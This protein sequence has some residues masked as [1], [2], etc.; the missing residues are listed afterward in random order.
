M[1]LSAQIKT[2]I[3]R[4]LKWYSYSLLYFLVASLPC[5]YAWYV[6]PEPYR[7]GI[8]AVFNKIALMPTLIL[9]GA[10][11]V[12][13]LAAI[14][15]TL[16]SPWLKERF[17]DLSFSQKSAG[18]SDKDAYQ[19][20]SSAN[21]PT[22]LWDKTVNISTSVYGILLIVFG[23]GIALWLSKPYVT[24]LFSSS[25]IEAL[26]RKAARFEFV[27]RD[28]MKRIMENRARHEVSQKWLEKRGESLAQVQEDWI[29]IPIALVD[30]PILEGLSEENLALG[31]CRVSESSVPGQGGNCIIEGHNLSDF[32]WWRPQG[33]F[34]MLEVLEEGVHIY[35]FHKG[36]KYVYQVK[37][38]HYKDANDLN[39]YDFTPGERLTLITC[40][41]SWELAAYTNKR[42]VIVAYPM[43]GYN[44]Q[45]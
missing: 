31:V 22:G 30:E 45:I 2:S 40:T 13:I 32:G 33:P 44:P 18:L 8:Q 3:K 10:I 21:K 27:Q 34:N 35:V 19:E 17:P 16:I 28:A 39:L 12:L 6:R 24:F 4:Y 36:K 38:K 37:E 11:T 7:A 20:S 1:S 25:K 41:S 29:I 23:L 15:R 9:I 42:T 5:A 26:E 43:K 14:F